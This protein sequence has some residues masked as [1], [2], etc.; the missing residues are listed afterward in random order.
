[1]NIDAVLRTSLWWHGATCAGLLLIAL[2][3]TDAA[4]AEAKVDHYVKL[5]PENSVIG[6]YPIQKAP[7]LTIQSGETV[8]IDTGGGAGWRSGN[9]DPDEWLK[10]NHVPTTS[11]NPALQETIAVLDK[12]VRYADIK[13]GHLLVGPINVDGAMPGDSL[14]IRIL[15]VVP[16]IPYG[17]TGSGPGRGLKELEG[18]KPPAHVTLLDL[19]RKVGVFAPGVEVPLRPFMGVM[20]LQPASSEGDNPSST[21]PGNYGGNL[22]CNELVTGTTLYLPVFQPGARFF[23][24]DAHAAQGDGE[25]TGT[26]IETANTVTLKFILH[27][28]Q[29]LKMPRAE[30]PTHWIAFGLNPDL[31]DALQQA[32]DQ[33]VDYMKDLKGWDMLQTLPLASIAVSYRITENVD[34]TKAVHAMIPK[35]VFVNDKSSYWYSAKS[36]GRS[37]SPHA[38]MED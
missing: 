20:A 1:M 14:E 17:T 35:N 26:A 21:P 33:T 13:T 15:S 32:V 28:G 34:K 12:T 36:G 16:R 24:G 18:P 9:V 7:I 30:S 2:L 37:A 5:T 38:S 27:K 4:A 3:S 31:D 11:A 6:N 25:I 22:D 23:T 10:S 19:K 8:K 29:A